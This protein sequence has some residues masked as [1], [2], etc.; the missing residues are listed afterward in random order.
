MS[1]E[2]NT[3]VV[4]R[5]IQILPVDSDHEK[6]FDL[7]KEQTENEI[8]KLKS[9]I[10][11]AKDE[12][13]K[14]NHKNKI[15]ELELTLEKAFNEN[16]PTQKMINNYVYGLLRDCMKSEAQMKNYILSNMFSVLIHEKDDWELAK[17]H[18]REICKSGLRVNG[19]KK[20]NL[21][22]NVDIDMPIGSYGTRFG[23]ELSKKFFDSVNKG[24]LYGKCSLPTYKMDSPLTVA[25]SEMGFTHGY[26]S[27]EELAEH[28][29][30]K[31]CKMFF[32]FGGNG[33]PTIAKFKIIIG[34]K[35]EQK[36]EKELRTTLLRLYSGEYKYC[37]SSIQFNKNGKKIILNLSLEIPNKKR[38]LDEN[39]V[40]GVDLGLAIPAMCAL[41]NSEKIK[42]SIGSFNDFQRVRTQMNKQRERLQSNMKYSKGGHG[43]KRKMQ[44]MEKY[45]NR[46]HNF[47]QTYNH[48]V[49]KRVV[50][51]AIKNNAKYINI[52]DL[53]S[54]KKNRD[55]KDE[56]QKQNKVLNNWTYY[57]LAEYITYKAG[58]NGIEV[59]KV[60][61]MYTSQTCHCCGNLEKGQR[62]S[63][64]E[65]ICK[66]PDCREYNK[67]QNADFNAA[68][69]ISM[70]TD[71]VKEKK[72][73][74]AQVV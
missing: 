27:F 55:K 3:Q 37:G 23:K 38:E 47:A 6:I 26:D 73:K 43:R 60:N 34:N 74:V 59:R 40:V 25:K 46:E 41:N 58:M 69:N 30:D 28:I 14:I 65:F 31:D 18:T 61:P 20:G 5:K 50:D 29:N 8:K 22:E 7:A 17:E 66:N 36:N 9:E 16:K 67:V 44:A 56:S 45:R 15:R 49:S 53:S 32:D 54:V 35:K 63:Q 48:M 10:R 11:K 2:K 62:V 1:K 64:A 42:E 19:S 4:T 21:Y 12:Q 24:L 57:M 52:E 71:F 70:S 33:K 68:R 39:V 51:F 72:T 13:T